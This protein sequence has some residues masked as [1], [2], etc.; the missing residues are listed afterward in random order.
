MVLAILPITAVVIAGGARGF[1]SAPAWLLPGLLPIVWYDVESFNL[2]YPLLDRPLSPA[3]QLILCAAATTLFAV[4][5]AGPNDIG[6]WRRRLAS[7]VLIS[8]WLVL[9]SIFFQ[10]ELSKLIGG[11]FACL[12]LAGCLELFRRAQLPLRWFALISAVFLFVL[13]TFF[14]NGFALSHVDFRF[15]GNKIF[16]FAKEAWRAPQ[17]ILWAALK[18]AFVL[19]PAL[20]VLRASAVGKRV[21]PQLLLLGWWRELTIV[22]GALGL[23]VFNARGM[24]DLCTEEI[25]FWTFLNLVLFAACLILPHASPSPAVPGLPGTGPERSV[26]APE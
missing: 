15:A 20:A 18:Y 22:A 9:G 13:L 7:L 5:F 16:L 17:L 19:L 26:P 10:F 6:R 11:L 14:L 24:R 3:T 21:W 12:W 4:V 25:Y 1:F 8:V 23:A 2:K